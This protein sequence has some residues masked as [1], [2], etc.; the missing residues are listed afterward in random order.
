MGSKEDMEVDE[1]GSIKDEGKWDFKATMER[2]ES[3]IRTNDLKNIY[4]FDAE[5]REYINRSF[6]E[7]NSRKFKMQEEAAKASLISP[8]RA[9]KGTMKDTEEEKIFI[10][11]RIKDAKPPPIPRVYGTITSP[12]KLKE[13]YD[14]IL[15]NAHL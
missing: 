6:L 9:L 8:I 14:Y 2:I 1:D 15:A 4:N 13:H 10:L 3:K 12:K 7:K 5:I 11:P